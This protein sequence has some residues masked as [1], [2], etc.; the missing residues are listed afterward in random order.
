MACRLRENISHLLLLTLLIQGLYLGSGCTN[1]KKLKE[2]NYQKVVAGLSM[3]SQEVEFASVRDSLLESAPEER[4]AVVDIQGKVLIMDAVKDDESGEMVITDRLKAVVV[5]AKFRNIAERNGFVDIAFEVSVPPVMLSSDWQVRLAPSLF[6]LD[7][8]LSLEKIYITGERYREEQLRGYELYN[9]FLNSILPDSCDFMATYT[10]RHLLETFLERNFQK[11]ARLKE[12]SSFVEASYAE[13]LFGVSELAA[14]EHYTKNYL[15]RRNNRRISNKEKMFAKYVK[16]P[17]DVNGVR[18]DSVVADADGTVRYHYVQ[19]IRSTKNLRKVDLI[20][21]GELY[22]GDK[23]LYSMPTSD[24]L[25]FYISSMTWFADRSTR[26]LKKIISRNAM[27]NTSAFIDFS[28]GQFRLDD[29]LHSNEKELERIK[30][31]VADILSI[32]DYVVDSL[33]ITAYCSPEGSF[34]FN[35]QLARKRAHSIKEYF[36]NYIA[37]Y[38][39]SVRN[40][41]WELGLGDDNKGGERGYGADETYTKPAEGLIKVAWQAEHWE[42]LKRLILRDSTIEGASIVERLWSI[43][44]PDTREKLL[45]SF[46][47]YRYIREQYY[48]L[49]RTVQFDFFL[50]RRGMIKDTIHT[51]EVDTLYMSGV[52][53]LEERDFQKAVTI[54]RPYGDLNSAVAYI[55]MDYNNSA[56]HILE[57]LPKS[58]FRDYMLAVVY[59][60]L[61]NE[62]MAVE[63]FIHSVAQDP[64]MKHRGNLD[65]EISSLV[66]KYQLTNL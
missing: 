48:P 26:Y 27:A 15:I 21:D 19:T 66:K 63:H 9:K 47:E 10:R 5:E 16:V 8:T 32:D 46:K 28:L 52:K 11:I 6:Y 56:L 24:T 31:N 4:I 58:A 40:S 20:L 35:S 60:R 61:G 22:K 45:R 65:P 49:L 18:L 7:D 1:R 64:F 3:G 17:I 62:Q 12:D 53:A 23:R 39:D 14:I 2:L 44:D 34:S 50:H 29:T 43:E 41:T 57:N 30:R 25:T 38:K 55:C 54:L 42:K 13:S 51:T 37:S 33:K 36:L 59:S